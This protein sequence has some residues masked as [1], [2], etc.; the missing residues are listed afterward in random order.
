MAAAVPLPLMGN[1]GV[2]YV[3][4]D[5]AGRFRVVDIDCGWPKARRVML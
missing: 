3:S 5:R 4:C 2:F 1:G